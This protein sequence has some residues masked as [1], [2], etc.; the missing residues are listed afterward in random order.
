MNCVFFIS[1]DRSS[2]GIG[3]SFDNID[4]NDPNDIARFRYADDSNQAHLLIIIDNFGQWLQGEWATI[5]GK[6]LL[7]C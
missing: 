4:L 2:C 7:L 5:Q 1:S 6:K 3:E